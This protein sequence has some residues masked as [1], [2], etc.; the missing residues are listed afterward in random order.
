MKYAVI[1]DIH[2]NIE[3]L[4]SALEH[5]DTQKVD[6]IICCGDLVGYYTN[7][8][9]C[10]N[11]LNRRSVT[12]IAGNHDLAAT[13][14][15]TDLSSFWEVAHKAILWTQDNLTDTSLDILKQLPKQI[16]IEN[17]FLLFHGSLHLEHN[18][19]DLHLHKLDDLR[20]SMDSLIKHKSKAKIGFFGHTHHAATYHF[21]NNTIQKI[22]KSKFY[23]QPDEYYLI[24][25][26]SIGQP[27]DGDKRLSY[28]TYDDESGE[29]TFFRLDYD[30]R[31]CIKKAANAGIW[32]PRWRRRLF[33]YLRRIRNKVLR[34][35]GIRNQ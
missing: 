14:E 1:S 31:A 6:K 26:G 8:N 22:D 20:L 7:P 23:L 21:N 32:E 15:K 17:K 33:R 28:L 27:R 18:A 12:S 3:A 10:I 25:P 11:L 19:E 4:T 5:I 24:N 9:E 16:T 2:A 30:I 35:I 13:G 34:V 29:V